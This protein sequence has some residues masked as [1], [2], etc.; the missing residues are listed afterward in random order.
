MQ[1][2]REEAESALKKIPGIR[3]SIEDAENRTMN[4][5]D[6]LDEAEKNAKTARKTAQDAH[7]KHAQQASQVCSS[8]G[9]YY[10]IGFIY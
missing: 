8:H 4:I 6:A 9:L 5:K 3:Q 7:H 2:S 1:T 10:G